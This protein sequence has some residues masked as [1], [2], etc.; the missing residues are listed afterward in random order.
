MGAVG[1][2]PLRRPDPTSLQTESEQLS[3]MALTA[4]VQSRD[5]AQEKGGRAVCAIG[6]ELPHGF[7]P[8]RSGGWSPLRSCDLPFI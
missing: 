5:D 3:G 1:S 2:S 4:A 7:Q 8:S 6:R